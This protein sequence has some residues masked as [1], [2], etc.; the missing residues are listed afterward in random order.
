MEI[1]VYDLLFFLGAF[2]DDTQLILANL[3]SLRVQ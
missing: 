3:H 2:S 1:I